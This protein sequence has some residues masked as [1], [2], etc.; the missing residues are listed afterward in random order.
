[1]NITIILFFVYLLGLGFTA[2]S[3][4]KIKPKYFYERLTIMIALGLSMLVLLTALIPLLRIPL[5]WK[6]ILVLS[7][8]Y[9]TCYIFKNFKKIFAHLVS[10]EFKEEI[11]PSI[12]IILLVLIFAFTFFMYHKGAFAY[13]YLE[14]DDP[15][16]HAIA[17]KYVATEKTVY[18]PVAGQQVLLYLDARGPGY[19]GIMG[20]LHQT[21]S[22]LSWTLKFFNALIISLGILFFF[23]FAKSLLKSSSKAILAT[24]FLAMIPTYLTHF[25]WTHSLA[26]TLV[27]ASLYFLINFTSSFKESF[28]AAIPIAAVFVTSESD[29][30]KLILLIALFFIARSIIM[31]KLDYKS[32]S[33]GFFGLLISAVLWWIPMLVKYGGISGLLKAGLNLGGEKVA[34][35]ALHPSIQGIKYFGTLGSAT[36]QHGVYTLKDIFFAEGQNMINVPIGVGIVLMCLVVLGVIYLLIKKRNLLKEKPELLALLFWFIFTFFGSNGGT[37]WWA[38]FAFYTF[39]FWLFFSIFCSIFAVYGVYLLISLGKKIKMPSII[40][41]LLIVTGVWFT[42][43]MQKYELNTATWPPGGSWTSQEELQGYLWLK[44]LPVNTKVFEVAG[45]GESVGFDKYSCMWCTDEIPY[46]KNANNY[47]NDQIY[48]L[49]KRK[50]YEYIAVSAKAVNLWG[51]NETN[52]FLISLNSDRRFQPA[53]STNGFFAFK[54]Q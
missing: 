14:D 51:L 10:K 49:L 54:I 8:G 39:R 41:I 35:S 17:A 26:L 44:T 31:K 9:P 21:S 29:S 40:I 52:K 43:G 37:R 27:I 25:I 24:F 42:S 30:I 2:L 22:S 46:Q 1:M 18:E 53:Y 50:G 28:V 48:S 33:A 23:Y 11:K 20:I 34:A 32:A 6:I 13:S 12:T 16:A 38:P 4:F 36:R 7:I 19:E 5:D 3:L 45:L 15:W 47:T